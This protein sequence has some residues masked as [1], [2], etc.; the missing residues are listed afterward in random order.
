MSSV[1]LPPDVAA[2]LRHA[3]G[4]APVTDVAVLSG[5]LS[6][7]AVFSFT[8]EGRPWVVRKGTMGDAR[9][10]I[11]CARIASD[12][13]V[14]P[15]IRHVDEAEAIVLMERIESRP[16]SPE[17]TERAAR[18]GRVLAALR[19]L[20]AGP[21][22]PAGPPVTALLAGIDQ[23]IR[24]AGGEGLPRVVHETVAEAAAATVAF[25][26]AAPC[27]KDL[28][29]NN[30]LDTGERVVF[31]DWE[32]ASQ[33]DPY[34]DVAQV[35]VFGTAESPDAVL[36]AYL[37]RAPDDRE[38]AHWTVAR[39]I[40]LAGYTSGF[41]LAAAFAKAPTPKDADA[42]SMPELRMLMARDRERAAPNVVAASLLA[43]MRRAATEPA[44]EGALR[45]LRG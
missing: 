29:P 30:I 26:A 35:T 24:R 7:A 45:T 23:M 16:F 6:G 5:G 34:V 22:F 27:H 12:L 19:T 17:P 4:D 1:A 18:L 20:H 15:R 36:A 40:A 9:H 44:Y 41:H 14:G 3:F 11:A 38:R 10:V 31:V 13:G 33:G 42:L 8:A 2:V 21:A 25:A 28:H 37:E 39:V 32:I 43:E